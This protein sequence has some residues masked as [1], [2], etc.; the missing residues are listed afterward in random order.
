MLASL[1]RLALRPFTSTAGAAALL[2]GYLFAHAATRFLLPG[3]LGYDDAEQVLFAQA[4][5]LGY[6]FQQPPLVTWLVL[7]LR[8]VVGLAPGLVAVTLVRTLLLATLY[9][10]LFLA[11]RQWL[12]DTTRAAVASA[13]VAT[14]YTLGFLAHADLLVST[15]LAAAVTT[16]LWLW[17]RLLVRPT[18]A[19]TI[20]FGIV[21]GV[22]LLAK[23]NF[24][25]L[26]V[27]YFVV[28]L[29]MPSSRALV[30]SWRT[31]AIVAIAGV[32]AGPTALWVLAHHP[33][34]GGLAGE[35]LVAPA[36]ERSWLAGVIQ[37]G[38]SAVAFPQPMVVLLALAAWPAF[39]RLPATVRPLAWLVATTFLLHLLLVPVAG[40]VN[41]P[42]RWMIAVELPVAILL[43]AAI[44]RDHPRLP[45]VALT[46]LAV[47]LGTW[48]A[49]LAI[50]LTDADYCGRC[51]TRLPV[52]A[53]VDGV[54]AA[55]FEDGTVV[56]LDM[57]LG[58][59]LQAALA[60]T[61]RVVMPSYPASIWPAPRDGGCLVVWPMGR[62]GGAALRAAAGLGADVEAGRDGE[63]LAPILGSTS[64]L[65][66]IGFRLLPGAGSCR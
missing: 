55:G 42:E 50:G 3:S 20:A 8:D 46:V 25:M 28:T 37:L 66:G 29:A 18:A 35:V 15:A 5:S 44:P 57:H 19:N 11:A 6:R 34:F 32:V 48:T 49:R 64:R 38:A 23:W 45:V 14:T 16:S 7:A 24:V 41:F 9:S 31:P 33:S 61:G 53:I 4:W 65:D 47:I 39:R 1:P 40:A 27:A 43:M 30:L 62:G 2:F 56:S 13:A 36:A 12:G 10:T 17:G 63:V 52:A 22:G 59:N 54:R 51:R 60:G 21:C 58:G 26:A